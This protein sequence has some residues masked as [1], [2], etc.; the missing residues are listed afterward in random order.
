ME[1]NAQ[2][3]TNYRM[4]VTSDT[5]YFKL[6]N[7]KR[8][9]NNRKEKQREAFAMRSDNNLQYVNT[10]Y[11]IY[12]NTYIIYITAPPESIKVRSVCCM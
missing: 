5:K 4:Y 1:Q 2:K 8:R 9:E 6:K 11:I 12:S 10:Y 7:N 3:H